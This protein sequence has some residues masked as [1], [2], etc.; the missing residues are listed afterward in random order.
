[1]VWL[2]IG[3]AAAVIR[4]PEGETVTCSTL[5]SATSQRRRTS[6]HE[7]CLSIFD[8]RGKVLRPL[9]IEVEHQDI[10]GTTRITPSNATWPCWSA[11]R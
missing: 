6:N 8:V 11:T 4:T 5:G 7:G 2:S 10:D 3:R 1:V 9:A